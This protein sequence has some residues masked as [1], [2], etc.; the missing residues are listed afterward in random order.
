M[1]LLNNLISSQ[2]FIFRFALIILISL[3]GLFALIVAI[4]IGNLNKVVNQ[5]GF[6]PFLNFAAVLHF[7]ATI[8]LLAVAV[9]SL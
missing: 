1:D 7:L 3:Y 9:L 5:I 6:S 8:A 4:Q 2:D